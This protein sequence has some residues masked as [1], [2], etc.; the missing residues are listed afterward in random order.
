MA[1]PAVSDSPRRLTSVHRHGS[2]LGYT[3][4][5]FEPNDNL[6]RQVG[7]GNMDSGR[8]SESVPR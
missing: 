4:A 7:S 5:D 8:G 6:L 1:R 2:G 3:Y